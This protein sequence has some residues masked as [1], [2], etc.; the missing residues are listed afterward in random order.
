MRIAIKSLL[1]SVLIVNYAIYQK[2][3]V[4]IVINSM[5]SYLLILVLCWRR[6]SVIDI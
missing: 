1:W 3:W 6:Q 4:L 2:E 5:H